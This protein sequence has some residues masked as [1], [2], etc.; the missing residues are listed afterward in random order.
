MLGLSPASISMFMER[1]EHAWFRERMNNR[2][3]SEGDDASGNW[4]PL[5]PATEAIRDSQGY[6]AA[7]PIN[8]RTGELQGFVTDSHAVSVQGDTV[9]LTIPGEDPSGE[10]GDKLATAQQGRGFGGCTAPST[11]HT[12]PRPVLAMNE[13]DLE[14]SMVLLAGWLG[15]VA[16][17]Q[18]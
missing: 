11:P 6:G 3:M 2:F 14:A 8:R 18:F 7:H 4:L 13:V 9:V 10:L 1:E 17:A 5:S 12:V 15:R 16:G